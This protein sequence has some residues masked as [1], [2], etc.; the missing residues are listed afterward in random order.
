M[1]RDHVTHVPP[2]PIPVTPPT[3]PPTTPPTLP[4]P[5]SP[6]DTPTPVPLPSVA[7]SA[8]NYNVNEGAGTVTITVTLSAA[9]GQNVTIDYATID[10][11]S[12]TPGNDYTTTN[13]T[14]LFIPGQTS[15]TFT[16]P[17]INDANVELNEIFNV[18]LSN[19]T[20]AT[21]G[22]PNPATVTIIDDDVPTV[23]FDS[24]TYSVDENAGPAIITVMRI[25]RIS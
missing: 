15:R 19:P 4:P 14:L 20:N 10:V 1:L 7:F 8:V 18:T 5:T 17:I 23:Q 12:A 3:V 24:A 22:A 21:L 9:S 13:N 2:T 25:K 6:P 11:G 16:V